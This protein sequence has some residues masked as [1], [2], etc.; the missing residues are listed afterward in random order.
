MKIITVRVTQDDIDRGVR[1]STTD[2]P[3]ARA[4]CRAVPNAFIRVWKDVA[5]VRIHRVEIP[6]KVRRFIHDFDDYRAVK[7]FSF[8]IDIPDINS[9]KLNLSPSAS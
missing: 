9:R 6:P 2:C 4:L 3:V 8:E 1:G 5:F 7:P